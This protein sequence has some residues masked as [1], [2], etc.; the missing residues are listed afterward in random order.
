M[1]AIAML[2]PAMKEYPKI[3]LRANVGI[4]SLITPMAGRS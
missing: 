1:T 2:E 3:G 4:I